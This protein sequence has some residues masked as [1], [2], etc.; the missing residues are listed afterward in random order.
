MAETVLGLLGLGNR[1]VHVPAADE[2][3]EGHHLLDGHERVRVVRFA[4]NHLGGGGDRLADG[5][6]Q[7]G[8]ILADEVLGSHVVLV[9]PFAHAGDGHL[10]EGVDL[11]AQSRTAPARSM[12]AI[13]ASKT[14]ATTKTSF[15]AMHS[16]LLS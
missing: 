15:S 4:E 7:H 1:L 5:L 9:S 13:I 3:Q 12:A 10:G 11:L 8:R 14:D 6:G 16:R 2:G